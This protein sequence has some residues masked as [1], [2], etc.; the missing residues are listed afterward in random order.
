SEKTK[1]G[2]LD[3][4]E[5]QKEIKALSERYGL[6]VDPTARVEAIS[7]GMQ[8]RVEILKTLYRGTD[9]LILDEPTAVLTPQEI[10]ELMEIMHSLTKEGKSIIIITHKLEE[11]KQVA[12]QC[13]V[14]RRG[15]SIDTVEVAET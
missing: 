5:A 1:A 15:Q 10:T 9:I 2:F 8:Q 12:D 7:V 6:F 4:K 11:I 14:I 3:K 13:T